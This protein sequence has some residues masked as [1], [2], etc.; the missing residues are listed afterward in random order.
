MALDAVVDD[1]E[2]V[3]EQARDFY[4]QTEDGKYR[5]D[6]SG[7]EFPEDVQGLKSALEKEREAA[8]Q[9]KSQLRQFENIDLSE[10][11]ALKEAEQKRQDELAARR[12]EFDKLLEKKQA[13]WQEEL[14]SRDTR[15]KELEGRISDLLRDQEARKAL[16]AHEANVDLLLPHVLGKVSLIEED[17]RH[18]AVVVGDEGAPRLNDDGAYMTI[19]QLVAEMAEDKRYAGAFPATVKT[20]GGATTTGSAGRAT[21]NIAG[22]DADIGAKV[23]FIQEK[24]L[25]AFRD[26]LGMKPKR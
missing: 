21:N 3:P 12:G 20:G 17:G 9:Y 22:P 2:G 10:I 23:K 18:L 14:Q 26:Q 7:V 1:I 15:V 4:T 8:K 16:A 5:L 11:Q 25:E 24:G 19:S 6:V 13:K